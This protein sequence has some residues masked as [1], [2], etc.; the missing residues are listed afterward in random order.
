MQICFPV[1]RDD[2][3]KSPLSKHFGSAPLFVIADTDKGALR[4]VENKNPH[5][6]HGACQPLRSLSGESL[7][8]VVV[9]GIGMGALTKLQKAKLR[10]FLAGA[11]RTVEE[12]LDAAKSGSLKEATAE[13]ACAHRGHGPHGHGRPMGPCRDR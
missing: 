8:S 5:H 10:V 1:T 11:H 9:G 12:A 4:A 13:S 7:D 2:G 6:S 3:P